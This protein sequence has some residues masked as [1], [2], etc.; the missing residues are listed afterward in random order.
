[1]PC[2]LLYVG[3]DFICCLLRGQFR[4]YISVVPDILVYTVL[5]ATYFSFSRIIFLVFVCKFF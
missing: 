2:A 5:P 1:M 4:E 3:A